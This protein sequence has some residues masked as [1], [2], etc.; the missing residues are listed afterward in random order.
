MVALCVLSQKDITVTLINAKRLLISLL[1][2]AEKHAQMFH[3]LKQRK[4]AAQHQGIFL[5][6]CRVF[7]ERQIWKLALSSITRQALCPTSLTNIDK[8]NTV[9]IR[10]VSATIKSRHEPSEVQVNSHHHLGLSA[11][12]RYFVFTSNA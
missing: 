4:K 8:Y 6:L 11:V 12:L 10:F 7:C 5:R 9:L 1:I 2:I 3:L